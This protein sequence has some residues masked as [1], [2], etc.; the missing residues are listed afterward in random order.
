MT[1]S[2]PGK[3]EYILDFLSGAGHEAYVVGG[4][5]RDAILGITPHDWDI[6]T[7]ALPSQ[8]HEVFDDLTVVDTGIKHGTVTVAVDGENFEITTFRLDGHYS[9]SRHPDSVEFTKHLALDLARR[10]FTINAMAYSPKRGVVDLFNGQQDLYNG[11][12]RCVRT[13]RERFS[14]DA[15]R[16]LRALR[17]ASRYGFYIEEETS[18][19][20]H[21]LARSLDKIAVERIKAEMDGI[22]VGKGTEQ[23]LREYVDVI[24]VVIPE[25]L[26]CVGFDQLNPFHIYDV[27]EHIVHSVGFIKPDPFLRWTMLFHDLGKPA[28]FTTEADGTRGHFYGHG[29]VSAEIADTI[30]ERLKF[31]NDEK[32]IIH[33]LVCEHD[34]FIE[35]APRSIRRLL[36]RLGEDQFDRYM[37]VRDADI[38]AQNPEKAP[39]RLAKNMLIR[40]L[41]QN[42]QF[43]HDCVDL[44]TLAIDGNDLLTIG[45]TSSPVL[46]NELRRLFDMVLDDP[47]M[48]IKEILLQV[49]LEDLN[50]STA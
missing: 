16:I 15:L 21:E 47:D 12:I 49:A 38:K 18:S 50:K 17:F 28:S 5:V 19:A 27:W 34:H 33:E 25:V 2:L 1:I 44:K 37:E 24:G 39:D 6:C 32:R 45:Y 42:V 7:S 8:V 14:E 31:S 11:I 10:D 22:L 26:P 4:C 30:M 23:V 20:I 43:Q 29:K 35:P 13:P 41:K 48:N 3:V 9:D 36:N 40:R 46:G